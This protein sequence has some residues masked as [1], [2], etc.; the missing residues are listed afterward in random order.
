MLCFIIQ[1]VSYGTIRCLQNDVHE[2]MEG[3]TY[4]ALDWGVD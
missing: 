2:F 3:E 1:I 4:I